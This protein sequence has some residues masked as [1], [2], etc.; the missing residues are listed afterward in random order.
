M[1]Y[2]FEEQINIKIQSNKELTLDEAIYVLKHHHF[3][4]KCQKALD[5]LLKAVET[6]EKI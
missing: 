3:N 1:S 6:K 5:V 4:W 2:S